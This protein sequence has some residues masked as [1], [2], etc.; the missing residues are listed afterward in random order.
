MKIEEFAIY[1]W[2]LKNA[3]KYSYFNLNR[4]FT[5][6]FND[7]TFRREKWLQFYLVILIDIDFIGNHDNGY[8]VFRWY[9]LVPEVSDF[10][11]C[12]WI[13]YVVNEDEHV[14]LFYREIQHGWKFV[15]AGRVKDLE[16][17]FLILVGVE[18]GT[19][20]VVHSWFVFVGNS[21]V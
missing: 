19:V 6:F 7:P 9:N 4:F 5:D 18:C 14:I 16:D 20:T 13:V 17:Q 3:C 8:F 21:V 11:E 12:D 10:P 1:L 2:R 15:G